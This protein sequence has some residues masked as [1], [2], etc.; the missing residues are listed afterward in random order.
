MEWLE[1]QRELL[2]TDQISVVPNGQYWNLKGVRAGL[3]LGADNP[4]PAGND[5][6]PEHANDKCVYRFVEAAGRRN[7][8]LMNAENIGL[9]INKARCTGRRNVQ[10]ADL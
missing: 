10:R 4:L 6:V 1:R 8:A 5:N 2:A 3:M 7:S 9:K